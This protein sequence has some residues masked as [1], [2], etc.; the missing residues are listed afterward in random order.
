MRILEVILLTTLVSHSP[1]QSRTA[2][3]S[4]A[5]SPS[6]VGYSLCGTASVS[7]GNRVQIFRERP[8]RTG[9]DTAWAMT[10]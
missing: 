8:I 3:S 6:P 5:A 10:Q 9:Y 7:D 1:P 2:L 4:G